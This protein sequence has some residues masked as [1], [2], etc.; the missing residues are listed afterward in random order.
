MHLLMIVGGAMIALLI[1]GTAYKYWEVRK[2]SN[3]LRTQGKVLSARSVARRVR[4]AETRQG[5][6]AGADLQLRN[7][8]EVRYEYRVNGK[9]FTGNRVSLGEDLGDFRV[10]ETLARYPEGTNVVVYYDPAR[11]SEAV[12]EHDAPEGVWRTMVLFILVL[13]VLF[14]GGTLGFDRAVEALQSRIAQPQ[15]AVPVAAFAGLALFMGLMGWAL[16]RQVAQARAWHTTQGQVLS[17]QVERFASRERKMN[18][19][20]T[21]GVISMRWQLLYRPDVAY[22]YSV[23]GVAYESNRISFGGRLYASFDHF[24][25]QRVAA[26]QSRGSVTVFYN[27]DNAAEAVLELRAYGEWVVWLLAAFFTAAALG[28]ALR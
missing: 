11:P 23:N 1:F 28:L 27:P 12:L 15:K 18:Q 7:F 17:S 4:T 9:R 26:Y 14:V 20:S 3:W 8:A 22:R 6:A 10:A 2:A 16:R 13:I 19:S 21:D 5:A 24:A 25:R